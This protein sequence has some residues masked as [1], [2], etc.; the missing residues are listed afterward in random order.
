M[1]KFMQILS[2]NGEDCANSMQEEV[3]ATLKVGSI[4]IHLQL[5]GFNW[6]LYCI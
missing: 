1:I 4:F 3:A 6:V 2:I 5:V